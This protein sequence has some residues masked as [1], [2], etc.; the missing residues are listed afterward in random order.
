MNQVFEICLGDS[1][2]SE[3]GSEEFVVTEASAAT[4]HVILENRAGRELTITI[5]YLFD[6]IESGVLIFVEPEDDVPTD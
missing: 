4:G 3:D 5:P 2:Q 6:L 1:F